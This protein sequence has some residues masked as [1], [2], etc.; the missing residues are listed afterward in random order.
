MDNS[1]PW[2]LSKTVWGALIVIAATLLRLT[3]YDVS[4]ADL[5]TIVDPVINV[6]SN[7]MTAI[8]AVMALVGRFKANKQIK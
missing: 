6:I 2:Y 7:T 8:G 3:G 1:K 5:Q 4:E